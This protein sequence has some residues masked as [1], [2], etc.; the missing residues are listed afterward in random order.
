MKG[1]PV[2]AGPRRDTAKPDAPKCQ[3]VVPVKDF[4]WVLN[5]ILEVVARRT[6]PA[7]SKYFIVLVHIS[8]IFLR[9]VIILGV[10]SENS[11]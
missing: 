3:A 11:F 7:P 4:I 10:F 6:T 9:C 2:S 1:Q 8:I 5:S